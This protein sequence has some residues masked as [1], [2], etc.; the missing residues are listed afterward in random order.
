MNQQAHKK[1][2]SGKKKHK[3]IISKFNEEKNN[4]NTL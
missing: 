2:L 4:I 3:H 1:T